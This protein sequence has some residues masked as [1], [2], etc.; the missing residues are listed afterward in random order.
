[1]KQDLKRRYCAFLHLRFCICVFLFC[2]LKIPAK[3]KQ[4]A[5]VFTAVQTEPDRRHFSGFS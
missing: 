3:P 2:F 5:A 1:M 4:A